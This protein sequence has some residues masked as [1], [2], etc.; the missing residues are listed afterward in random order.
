[1]II[2]EEKVCEKIDFQYLNNS[3]IKLLEKL[4]TIKDE[5]LLIF[6]SLFRDDYNF[7]VHKK[8]YFIEYIKNQLSLNKKLIVK[9][10]NKST[11]FIVKK[12][13]K[14]NKNLILKK[15]YN[16]TIF[17]NKKIK[18][19]LYFFYFT[20]KKFILSFFKK[21]KFEKDQNTNYILTNSNFDMSNDLKYNDIQ[22]ISEEICSREDLKVIHCPNL[23][24]FNIFNLSKLFQINN[25]IL[26]EHYYSYINIFRSFK[27][28]KRLNYYDKKILEYYDDLTLIIYMVIKHDKSHFLFFESLLNYYSFKK[29]INFNIKHLICWWENQITTKMIFKSIH[30][31]NKRINKVAYLG[32]PTRNLDLRILYSR[33]DQMNNFLPDTIYFIGDF[34]KKKYLNFNKCCNLNLITSKRYSYLKNYKSNIN[35]YILVSLPI[36]ED[37]S[38]KIINILLN[39]INLNSHSLSNFIISVHPSLQ[40]NKLKRKLS[41]LKK[42]TKFIGKNCFKDFLNSSKLVVGSS[43]GTIIESLVCGIPVALINNNLGRDSYGIPDVINEKLISLFSNS[44]QLL[45]IINKDDKFNVDSASLKKYIFNL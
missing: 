38:S 4:E 20:Y 43:S 5:D 34:Y 12:F 15:K 36:F 10:T 41:I 24:N 7:D 6:L 1:M 39:I 13:F 17:K 31:N 9:I 40:T 14:N 45:E 29:I 21:F 8:V 16:Q 44:K 37:E 26:K 23:I 3:N 42:N 35:K 32:Y 33:F 27:K 19:Y 2:D 28:L 22:E 18:I 30:D 11:F 25:I